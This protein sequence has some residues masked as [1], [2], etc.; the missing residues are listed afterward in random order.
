MPPKTKGG[1]PASRWRCAVAC[2]PTPPL[3]LACQRH[4]AAYLPKKKRSMLFAPFKIKRET[5]HR[6]KAGGDF[7]SATIQHTRKENLFLPLQ[8]HYPP[9][10]Q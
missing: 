4:A 3:F 6:P 5:M 2:A 9:P 8:N 1:F 10:L 7:S